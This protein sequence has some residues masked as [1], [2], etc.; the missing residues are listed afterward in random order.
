MQVFQIKLTAQY[1]MADFKADITNLY[2][3]SSLKNQQIVFLFTDQQ[4]V[5]RS[6]SL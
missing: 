2:A 1:G 5:S 6:R 4:C 3:G